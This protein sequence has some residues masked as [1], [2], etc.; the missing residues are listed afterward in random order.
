V[1]VERRYECDSAGPINLL[2]EQGL[3]GYN[4]D[5]MHVPKNP[6]RRAEKKSHEGKI[7]FRTKTVRE[8]SNRKE[9]KVHK[10]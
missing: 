2:R 4:G 3:C 8:L 10:K 1:E 7:I 6:V 5:P 9:G